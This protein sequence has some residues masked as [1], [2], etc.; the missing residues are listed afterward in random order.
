[1]AQALKTNWFA[2]SRFS[3]TTLERPVRWFAYPFGGRSIFGRERLPL[4]FQAGYEGVVSGH[5][6]FIHRHMAGQIL[7][8]I[9]RPGLSQSA[10]PRTAPHRLPAV[11]VRA[12]EMVGM[13][14]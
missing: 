11:V 9:P 8:R 13:K 7:P 4:V 5:G 10:E 1:M 2:P 14:S 3:K 6:G 12:E